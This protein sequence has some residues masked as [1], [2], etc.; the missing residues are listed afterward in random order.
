L[1]ANV[2]FWTGAFANMLVIVVLMAVAV[3]SV[4]TGDVTRHK[5]AMVTAMGLVVA[6][7]IAYP[8]KVAMLGREN[9]SSWSDAAVR[10]LHFHETCVALML[11]AGALALGR[12]WK[13]RKTRLVTRH[14]DDPATPAGTLK[15]H[16]RAGW[17]AVAAGVLGFL[18]AGFVLSGMYSRL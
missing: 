17:V 15:W 8:V 6:F 13:L 7:L 18:S 5:R 9:L 14:P 2:V 1:D 12:A 3:S 4:R 16:R 10:T 11:L